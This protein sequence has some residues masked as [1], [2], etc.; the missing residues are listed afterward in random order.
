MALI[1]QG[2]ICVVTKGSDAGK[3][4]VVKQVLDKNFVVIVGESVKERKSNIKHLEFTSRKG[5]IPTPKKIEPKVK[6]EQPKKRKISLKR[7]PKKKV[8]KE[9]EKKPEK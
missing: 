9:P 1:E 3:E 5:S 4:V 7:K 8:K 2:R 6:E